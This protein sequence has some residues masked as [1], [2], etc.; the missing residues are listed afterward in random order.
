MKRQRSCLKEGLGLLAAI[1][2]MV[3]ASPVIVPLS[4]VYAACCHDGD[5][6]Y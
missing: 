5:I 6:K 2:V 4:L 3:I 1:S